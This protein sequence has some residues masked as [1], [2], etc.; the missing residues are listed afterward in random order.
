MSKR[1]I[2]KYVN[3]FNC[4]HARALSKFLTDKGFTISP[5]DFFMLRARE[6]VGGRRGQGFYDIPEEARTIIDL[7]NSGDAQEREIAVM[8]KQRLLTVAREY[9]KAGIIT[10]KEVTQ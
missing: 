10:I 2:I 7:W 1:N 5:L 9:L 3:C 4:G 6:Q 8:I